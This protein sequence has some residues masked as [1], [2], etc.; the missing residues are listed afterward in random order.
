MLT[1]SECDMLPVPDP[2]VLTVILHQGNDLTYVVQDPHTTLWSIHKLD[3]D[4][5]TARAGRSTYRCFIE[6]KRAHDAGAVIWGEKR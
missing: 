4:Q 6:V 1:Q 2:T 5:G 3:I